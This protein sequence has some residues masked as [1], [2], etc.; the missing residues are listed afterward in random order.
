M[1]KKYIFLTADIHVVGG[2]QS[3]VACKSDFLIKNNYDINV[4]YKGFSGGK[5][6]IS[7]LNK[8]VNY[9]IIELC[10]PPFKLPKKIVSKVISKMIKIIGK[11]DDYNEIIIESQDDTTSQWGEILASKIKAKHFC[12]ICNERFKGKDKFYKEKMDFY[13]FKFYRKE[14]A[15][16]KEES[17]QLLFEDKKTLK[18]NEKYFLNCEGLKAIQDIDDTRIKQIK[19]NMDYSI[20]YVGRMDKGY[21]D[22][23]I[24]GIERFCQD[25][26]NK[27]IQV[28]FIG[29]AD[30]KK[31]L[32][33]K[34]IS[35]KK[36][37]SVLLMGDMVPIPKK[38]IEKMD[39]AIGGSGSAIACARAGTLTL[40]ADAK[41]FLCNGLLG[42]ETDNFLYHNI[43]EKQSSFYEALKRVLI[44]KNYN[45]DE[46]YKEILK[47]NS[48]ENYKEHME[49]I[50]NS[51][52]KNLYY[53][54]ELLLNGKKIN[55]FKII[56][57]LLNSKF[58]KVAKK[59]HSIKDKFL[60]FIKERRK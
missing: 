41:N 60:I 11:L 37:V 14:I 31:K 20:C 6:V 33:E 1:K 52:S 23:I 43:D 19:D 51:D 21:V 4:I 22:N 25:N 30:C 53:D 3:Y 59:Y 12:M 27:K 47:E 56:K 40:V 17:L 42:Y 49:F 39:I 50:K 57:L 9:G 2:M 48:G 36:N 16:I 8:H 10:Y 45:K 29:K 26:I 38:I 58:P 15:G 44:D 54:I 34:K 7:Q 13:L 24:N 28:V 18:D 55:I 35:N 32:I 5:C 46:K